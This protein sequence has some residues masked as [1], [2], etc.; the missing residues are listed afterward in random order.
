M[1][2]HRSHHLIGLVRG[3]FGD[4]PEAEWLDFITAAGFGGWEEASAADLPPSSGRHDDALH[5]TRRKAPAAT[6]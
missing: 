2:R 1:T 3:Q 4:V 5:A 6:S